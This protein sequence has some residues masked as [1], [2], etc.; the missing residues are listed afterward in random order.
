MCEMAMLINLSLSPSMR[1]RF[2][3]LYLTVSFSVHRIKFNFLFYFFIVYKSN[4]N[5]YKILCQ[6]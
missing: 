4:I 6:K 5:K 2:V 3:S 1:H